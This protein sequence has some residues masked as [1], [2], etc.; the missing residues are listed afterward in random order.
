MPRSVYRQ[1][2]LEYAHK[3]AREGDECQLVQLLDVLQIGQI[4]RVIDDQILRLAGRDN[5]YRWTLE[6][7]KPQRYDKDIADW[8][9]MRM[10]I[11]ERVPAYIK[12]RTRG[13]LNRPD[14]AS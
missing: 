10:K 8:R 9:R 6:T 14:W 5:R 13:N 2:L 4:E 12:K 7:H 1:M 11:W 3:I